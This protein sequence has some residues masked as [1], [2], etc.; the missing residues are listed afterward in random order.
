MASRVWFLLGRKLSGEA[1]L[2]ELRELELLLLYDSELASK[3]E[4]HEKYFRTSQENET[5]NDEGLNNKWQL[6]APKLRRGKEAVPPAGSIAP[7][8]KAAP[9]LNKSYI[10]VFAFSLAIVLIGVAFFRNNWSVGKKNELKP[11]VATKEKERTEA[12]LPDGT[13]VWLNSS[14]SISLSDGFGITNREVT[15]H[16]E[17]FFDVTHKAELP[18]IVHANKV[19]IMVKGTAFNVRAY[20]NDSTVEAILVRGSVEMVANMRDRKSRL[21]LKPNE[22]VTVNLVEKSI[23]GNSRDAASPFILDSL[24]VEEQSGLIPEI[25]WIQNKLVFKNEPFGILKKRMEQWYN[26]E[27]SVKDDS[28]LKE[29]FTG[30]FKEETIEE[31]LEALKYS[32]GFSYIIKENKIE[33]MR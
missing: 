7:Q 13:K 14:S 11:V 18:M 1:T 4:I 3:V 21:L 5:F 32:Y 23:T 8:Q 9:R 30:I 27:I 16:G 6:I 22:K 28:L 10:L 20:K 2:D 31:A 25:A 19:N 26:V 24:V 33:I 12:V 17:A 15:L 29:R